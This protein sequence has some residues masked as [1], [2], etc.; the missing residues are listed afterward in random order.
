[1]VTGT[2]QPGDSQRWRFTPVAMIHTV[3]QVSSNRFL[4]AH[5]D[6][7]EDYSAVTRPDE[8]N[9]TQRWVAMPVATATPSSGPAVVS[10]GAPEG[11]TAFGIGVP[12]QPPPSG[13]PAYTLR[14]LSSRRF[15]DAHESS[16]NDYAA[17]T[18]TA[19]FNDTQRWVVSADGD[20]YTV[21]QASTGR[22]LDA[23]E[24]SANDYAAVTRT[25][26][27]DNTQRW[28]FTPVGAVY[29]IQQVS[30]DRYLDAHETSG[31]DYSVVT[32]TAQHDDTQRWVVTRIEENE[33]TV[34]QLS[35]A[36]FLDAYE[37]E[38]N[39][40]SVVTRTAQGNDTQ[41]WVI[42]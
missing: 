41:R 32:R 38:P 8:G 36:R 11:E 33:Y 31:K 19:Q 15:L 1:V 22:F 2:G 10:A 17:V 39:G 3:Q 6:S 37:S 27:G 35:S 14:Q 21:V 30:S 34:V 4:D 5:E 16:A 20:A 42:T 40:Y 26:Q 23:H 24:S 18:R 13:I 12:D 7:A 9:D 28:T 25:A 29:E